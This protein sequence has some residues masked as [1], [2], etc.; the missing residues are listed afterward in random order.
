MKKGKNVLAR[1]SSVE[2]SEALPGM[3]LV[4]MLGYSRIL[5]E[6]HKGVCAYCPGK[7]Q[8]KVAYGELCVCGNGLKLAFMSKQRLVINGCIETVTLHRKGRPNGSN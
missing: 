1:L 5:I 8:I 2:V 7:I 4:E 6:N 3:A